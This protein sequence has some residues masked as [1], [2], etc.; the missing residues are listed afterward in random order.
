[1]AFSSCFRLDEGKQISVYNVVVDR[2]QAMTQT[3]VDPERPVFEPLA[4]Q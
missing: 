4:G 1:M 3:P 2:A